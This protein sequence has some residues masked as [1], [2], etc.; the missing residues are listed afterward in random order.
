MDELILPEQSKAARA[1]LAWSQ[2]ELAAKANVATSTVADFE[3]GA[4]SPMAN[5][6]Q[7]IREAFEAEG[8]QFIAGGVVEK[9]MLPQPPSVRPGA[10]MRWVNATHLS[11]WGEQRDGQ[12]GMPELLSRLIYATA[13]PSATL[14]F[15]SDE[16]IQYPGWDGVC[17]GAMG[18]GFVPV[19]DS[20][21]EIGAQ[22]MSIRTKAEAD[23]VK[24]ST[25]PLG[26]NPSQT[27]YVFVTPQRFIGKDE[28]V[29]EKKAL[30]IWRDVCAIDGNDLVH[31]LEMYPAVA[32]WLSVK[33]GRRPQ[34]LRNM[35]E[36][37]EEWLRATKTPLTSD[38]ILTGRD[39]DQTA[40]LK[41]LRGSPQL[42][43]VQAEA[44]DEAMAFLYAAISPLPGCYRLSYLSRCVVADT[45]ETAR[46]LIGLGTPLIIVLTDPDPGLAQRLVDD[47]HHVFAAYGPSANDLSG[48]LRR[49]PRPW[50][51]DLQMAL[52]HV[53]LSEEDAHRYTHASGRSITVLRRLMPAAPSYRPKWAEQV[54]PELIAAMLAGAWVETS[55]QDRKIISELTGRSYEQVEEILAPLAATLGGPLVRSGN[56]W[57]VVSLRDLWTQVG[58]QLT[59][60]QLT[61]FECVFHKVLGT[62]N[63]RFSI[64]PKSI[65]YEQEGEFGKE[66]S[67]ALREGLTEAIIAMAVYPERAKLITGIASR[68]NSIIHKLFDKAEA[69]LWWSLSQDFH[70]LAEAAPEE[71][72]EAVENGLEG[73]KPPIMSLFRSDEGMLHPTEYLSNLLWALEMLARSPDYLPQAALLL[74][75]LDEVDPGGKWGNRPSASLRR[76]FVSW[77]PQT[78]AKPAQRL[79]AIDMVARQY[80]IIG[81][82][83]LLA[84]APRLHDT[85]EPSSKPNWRDFTPD[86]PE[87][88]TWPSVAAAANAIGER[89]LEHVGDDCERW[90]ALLDLWANFDQQWRASATKQ[91][92]TFARGLTDSH[93]I[94][95]MRDKLRGLLQKH[96]GFKDAQ[97]AMME[98]DLKPLDDVFEIL[99]PASIEEQVR[100]LFR[101]GAETLRPDI[102]WNSQ[103]AEL[104]VKQ[105]EA[106][107]DLL[108]E[109]TPEQLFSFA[110]TITMHHALGLAIAMSTATDEVKLTLLKHG[111]LAD[112]PAAAA[113]GWGILNGLKAQKDSE[114][115]AWVDRLWNQAIAENWGEQAETRI[116]HALPPV[117]LTWLKIE[118]R[119]S[120]LSEAYWRSIS[121]YLIPNDTDT[122]YVADRLL[123]VG[124]SRDAVSWLGHNIGMKPSGALLVRVLRSAAKSDQLSDG[125]NATMLSHYVG[126]ILDVL[127]TD[128]TVGE[129]D[130]VELEWVYFQT[131]RYSRRKART[132]HRALARDPEF[133]VHLIKLI[134][135]PAADSKVVEPEPANIE[136]AR[137]L[138]SQAYDVMHDWTHVPGAD[139]QGVIDSLALES[140]VKHARK[141]LAEA[142]RTEIGDSKIG[143]ILSAAKRELDQPWPPIPVRD[144]IELIRSRNMEQGFEVG[145]YNRRGVTVRMPHDGGGQERALAE[146]YRRDAE[147]L[148]FDW[149]RTSAC[150]DRIATTYEI[151]A[152]REDLSAEQRDWL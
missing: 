123:S 25:N 82:K 66:P 92:E 132:L 146:R 5:N 47:G 18:T 143:E 116:V 135:L 53:G 100:W 74:A 113:V 43:S 125:N 81:W 112:E 131:L 31:W 65:Y 133:F 76:I 73:T 130:V 148:R 27:T 26:V 136:N 93:D 38:V 126:V 70:N 147:S 55:Q 80:P 115:D 7:A 35:E 46:Q 142:G 87:V 95:T 121:S 67:R 2:Q 56:V 110:S 101:P 107:Q 30:G 97:W 45:T 13:G 103:Q 122:T 77:S 69:S 79:K 117:M 84:L 59:P 28:W 78:Y 49:L 37:W 4:R 152:N 144:V 83:L 24:R 86:E 1:L 41:W 94:E 11:Q 20:V 15:P 14:H 22:R 127:E 42:L 129:K 61:R 21:W 138:A 151:D 68:V 57:K 10:L 63:P 124:R 23:F 141:R 109:L 96:R 16:S 39:D 145:V 19:G 149:P 17:R 60:S 108:T 150:L 62:I 71:F 40:V 114:G 106:I 52:T 54:P 102:D 51:F 75:H 88:I 134:Y 48:S 34:G 90:L 36:V 137:N 6:A 3:R 139:E 32:Q 9:A 44:P 50:K 64:P 105:R 128:G 85:S 33:I 140:W 29:T 99:Q 72:L 120:S 111:L 12:S 118:A 98:E 104:E 119:A 8:L 91:L 58:G 89:L